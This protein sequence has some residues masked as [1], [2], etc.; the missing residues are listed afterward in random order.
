M[1]NGGIAGLLAL[2]FILVMYNGNQDK[3]LEE[4]KQEAGFIKW[5]AALFVLIM[6]YKLTGGKLG[7]VVKQIVLVA[8]AALVLGKGEVIFKQVGDTFYPEKARN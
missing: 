8:L 5:I 7:D 3:L 6:I 1:I 4:I 2:Y